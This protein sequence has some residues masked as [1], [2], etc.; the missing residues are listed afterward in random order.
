MTVYF[1]TTFIWAHT[2][3]I[4]MA[5]TDYRFINM[6]L[7]SET[8]GGFVRT[9]A[10]PTFL[11][12]YQCPWSYSQ[13]P[14]GIWPQIPHIFIN[15]WGSR[16]FF[17]QSCIPQKTGLEKHYWKLLLNQ[18]QDITAAPARVCQHFH[19]KLIFSRFIT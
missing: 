11:S 7:Y 14:Q 17:F 2:R 13:V 5:L 9:A 8:S 10:S 18:I 19:Y 3:I 4:H 1:I 16:I 12:F 6:S 15:H